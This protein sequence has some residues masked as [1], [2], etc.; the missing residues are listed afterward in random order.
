MQDDSQPTFSIKLLSVFLII[1]YLFSRR[2]YCR[3]THM[4]DIYESMSCSDP[5][6]FYLAENNSILFCEA[7]SDGYDR[8]S[9]VFFGFC[10]EAVLAGK[11][12]SYTELCN[13]CYQSDLDL[14][15]MALNIEAVS[16]GKAFLDKYLR[17]F[18]ADEHSPSR[19]SI[20]IRGK[21]K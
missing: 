9:C 18:L 10:M 6:I 4:K 16:N 20:S 8:T 5:F 21:Y 1:K 17:Q 14:M 11:C 15:D 12:F 7:S 3:G 13:L 19:L 2:K